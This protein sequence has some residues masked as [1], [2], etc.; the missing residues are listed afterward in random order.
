MYNTVGVR[1]RTSRGSVSGRGDLLVL[2][3]G[4]SGAESWAPE[5][6]KVKS[7][8][9]VSQPGVEFLKQCS[10]SYLGKAELK[11]VKITRYHTRQFLLSSRAVSFGSRSRCHVLDFALT[12]FNV[13]F[14]QFG[15][16]EKKSWK[17]IRIGES[18]IYALIFWW[19]TSSVDRTWPETSLNCRTRIARRFSSRPTY[20]KQRRALIDVAG[21]LLTVELT[22]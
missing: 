12:T 4:H 3:F 19:T 11:W 15:T 18:V 9:S 8:W 6:P 5:C 22:Y 2:T 10:P 14:L 1:Y 13:L 16:S 7:R 20:C 17:H 21:L